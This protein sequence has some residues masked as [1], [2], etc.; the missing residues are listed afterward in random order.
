MVYRI[1]STIR[2]AG[3]VKTSDFKN[4]KNL[5]NLLKNINGLDNGTKNLV[6][7]FFRFNLGYIIDKKRD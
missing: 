5:Y 6:K 2:E 4:F 7:D 3:I 1:F